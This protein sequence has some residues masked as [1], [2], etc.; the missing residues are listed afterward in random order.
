MG[1]GSSDGRMLV[2]DECYMYI[3]MNQRI[4]KT[5][6]ADVGVHVLC[7]LLLTEATVGTCAMAGF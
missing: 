4:E 3:E 6:R 5:E 1:M 2:A 7:W